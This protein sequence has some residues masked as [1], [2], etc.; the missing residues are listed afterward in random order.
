MRN[1]P[2]YIRRRRAHY[3]AL[4]VLGKGAGYYIFPVQDSDTLAF[5]TRSKYPIVFALSSVSNTGVLS[6]VKA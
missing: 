5:K 2:A 3:Q 1:E 6:F 4:S